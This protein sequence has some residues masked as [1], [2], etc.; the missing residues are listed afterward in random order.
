MFIFVIPTIYISTNVLYTL[1]LQFCLLTNS[2]RS[3]LFVLT[4]PKTLYP[5]I[6]TLFKTVH[7]AYLVTDYFFNT[8]IDRLRAI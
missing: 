5:F 1:Y 7:V 3:S 4:S 6:F 2:A 8:N